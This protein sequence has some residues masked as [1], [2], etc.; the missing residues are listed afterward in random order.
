MGKIK[1][2]EGVH[3]V[4]D[5]LITKIMMGT[6]GC[7]PAY[8]RFFFDGTKKFGI[9]TGTFNEKSI[10]DISRFYIKNEDKLEECRTEISKYG[11][12][13]PQMKIVDMCFWQ[14]GYDLSLKTVI[15]NKITLIM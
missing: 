11:I 6:F 2:I 10:T 14:I 9:A 7:V 4:T 8:D 5:T 13:Y 12:E 1:N 3:N 15:T